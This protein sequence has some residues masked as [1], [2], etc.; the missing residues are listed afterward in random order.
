MVPRASIT[1]VLSG[2]SAALAP[3]GVL[4]VALNH[5]N[6][7]LVQR[8]APDAVGVAP[9]LGRELARRLGMPVHF[10]GYNTA[11]DVADAAVRDEW[12]V[13]LIGADPARAQAVRFTP[14]YTA[15]DATYLVS[16]S[17]GITSIEQV[18]RA[19]MRIAVAQRSAYDLFLRRHV[20]HASLVDAPNLP[21]SEALFVSEGLEVLA[22]LRA[23][24][25]QVA[26]R[27]PGSRVLDGVF[28]QVQQAMGVPAQRD[29]A[30][31]YVAD[32]VRDVLATGLVESY[33]VAHEVRGLSRP[34]SEA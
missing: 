27:V 8:P 32:F 10:I 14:P 1:R 16:A 23:H 12:D 26:P 20:R 3:R 11:G 24:L 6:F 31:A 19:G 34:I 29:A 9:D 17:S 7:L 33:I 30:F 13:A 2:A 18:D 22:G 5:A 28:M 4:R 21:E 15:I 25:L